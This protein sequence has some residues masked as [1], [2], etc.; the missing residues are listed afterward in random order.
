MTYTVAGHVTEIKMANKLIQI[1][2][3]GWIGGIILV[4]IVLTQGKVFGLF[5]CAGFVISGKTILTIILAYMAGAY[6]QSKVS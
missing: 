4:I 6:I 2:K 3:E 1:M 5:T